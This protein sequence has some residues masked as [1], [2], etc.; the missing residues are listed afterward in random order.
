MAPRLVTRCDPPRLDR[1]VT[2]L[3]DRFLDDRKRMAV[4]IS[5]RKLPEPQSRIVFIGKGQTMRNSIKMTAALIGCISSFLA[6][7]V[8]QAGPCTAD[9]AQ[10]ETLMRQSAGDPNAGLAAPQSIDAQL[11]HQPTQSSVRRAEA[12]LRSTFA[13]RMARAKLLDAQDDPRCAVSL[14]AAKKL[15]IP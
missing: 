2:F 4:G 13:A 15:Y 9:I 11:N 7:G 8:A 6:Y 14:R 3:D 10:F 1:R 5:I 12:R